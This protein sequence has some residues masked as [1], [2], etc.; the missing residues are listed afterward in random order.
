MI[1]GR[2]NAGKSSLLNRLA[3]YEAAIVAAVPGTTRDVLRERIEI[4][5]LP[6]HV[7]DTA[8]LR[9]G[10]D[11]IEREGIRRAEAEIAR[12]DRVLYVVDSADRASIDALPAILHRCRRER[13]RRW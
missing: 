13:R 3:G 12:A 5:G 2:P 9:A 8:G 7:L 11:E 6:L 10:G 4:D 1:A